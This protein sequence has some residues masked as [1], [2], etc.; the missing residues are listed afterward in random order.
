MIADDMN[1]NIRHPVT[2]K[3][4]KLNAKAPAELLL[5]AGSPSYLVQKNYLRIHYFER[6]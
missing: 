5:A 4:Q 6:K 2:K 1:K 3:L